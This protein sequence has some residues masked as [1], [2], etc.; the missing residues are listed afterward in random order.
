MD[1]VTDLVARRFDVVLL[2]VSPVAVTWAVLQLSPVEDL[3]C[4]LW[5]VEH[6]AQLEGL[7]RRGLA[8][9]EWTPAEPLELAL[10]PLARRRRR[11]V[12]A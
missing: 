4:R 6:R 8:V 10:A 12:A 2:A 1:A 9:V 5:A 11:M 7:H 3:A